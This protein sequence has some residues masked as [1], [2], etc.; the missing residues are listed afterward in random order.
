M[1]KWLLSPMDVP[2]ALLD[3]S[4][5]FE[6]VNSAIARTVPADAA[7]MKMG[8][9]GAAE[10]PMALMD[11]HQKL[12][13]KYEAKRAAWEQSKQSGMENATMSTDPQAVDFY[14]RWLAMQGLEKQAEINGYWEDLVVRGYHHRVTEAFGFLDITTPGEQIASKKA[15]IRMSEEASIFGGGSVFPVLMEPADWATDL[16][17]SFTPKDL[18]MQPENIEDKINE[19]SEDILQLSAQIA[20][21]EG[22]TDGD[23]KSAQKK[24]AAARTAFQSAQTAILNSY[25]DAVVTAVNAYLDS[26]YGADASKA[27]ADQSPVSKDEAAELQKLNRGSPISEV[28]LVPAD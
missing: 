21:I 7:P 14:F 5:E 9:A 11:F 24:V 15:D 26:K 28:S 3:W 27:S 25:S 23:I 4:A 10:V 1:R 6:A 20:A 18:T 16:S 13:L 8:D 12:L 17:S 19:L 2:A 22:N